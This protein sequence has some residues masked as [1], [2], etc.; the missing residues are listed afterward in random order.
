MDLSARDDRVEHEDALTGAVRRAGDALAALIP[1]AVT[2]GEDVVAAIEAACEDIEPAL[3]K[4]EVAL[5]VVG[6]APARRALL[7]AV[8]G[9]V[10]GA[11]VRGSRERATRV[12]ASE[13]YD[14]TARFRDGTVVRFARAMPDRDS[15]FAK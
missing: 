3:G 8:L 6:D 14:Y 2:F 11:T 5:A 9:D 1:Y 4:T 12:R 7:R 13:T 15:L 10:V